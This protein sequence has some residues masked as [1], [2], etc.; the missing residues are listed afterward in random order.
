MIIFWQSG[1]PTSSIYYPWAEFVE[2][3]DGRYA[4]SIPNP[5]HPRKILTQQDPLPARFRNSQ[6][7]RLDKLFGQV[8]NGPSLRLVVDPDDEETMIRHGYWVAT[9]RGRF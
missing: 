6:V 4:A 9:L 3:D 2:T 8:A 5:D 1:S 7:E